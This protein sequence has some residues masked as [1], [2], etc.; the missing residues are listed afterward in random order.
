MTRAGADPPPGTV[1]C[2]GARAVFP[3][4]LSWSAGAA[5]IFSVGPPGFLF[6]VRRSAPVRVL[7]SCR[8][9]RE[10]ILSRAGPPPPGICR[11]YQGRRAF[12]FCFT[13]SPGFSRPPGPYH[14][15]RRDIG[16]SGAGFEYPPGRRPSGPCAFRGRLLS[17]GPCLVRACQLFPG[18]CWFPGPSPGLCRPSLR[19]CCRFKQS[20]IFSGFPL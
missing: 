20:R 11:R 6:T 15:R 8:P 9:R 3:P 12:L 4:G 5:G 16:V 17:P 14:Y 1:H 18:L 13:R 2:A 19:L 7:C 10:D